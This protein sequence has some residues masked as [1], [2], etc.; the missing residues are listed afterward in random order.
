MAIWGE[1][2]SGMR[3]EDFYIG[4]GELEEGFQT[5]SETEELRCGFLDAT[6]GMVGWY[7]NI[8]LDYELCKLV[9]AL[10]VVTVVLCSGSL[11][12]FVMWAFRS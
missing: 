1:V 2:F 12:A 3:L 11:V 6:L 7:F 5:G 10:T 9:G 8:K 4:D